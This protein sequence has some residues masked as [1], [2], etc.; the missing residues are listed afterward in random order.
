M[1]FRT[2]NHKILRNLGIKKAHVTYCKV[3]YIAINDG[4]H[5]IGNSGSCFIR[6]GSPPRFTHSNCGNVAKSLAYRERGK[7]VDGVALPENGT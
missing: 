3:C 2:G 1:N 5:Y 7:D 4:I 6:L